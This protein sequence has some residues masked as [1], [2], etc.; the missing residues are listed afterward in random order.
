M[1]L[2]YCFRIPWIVGLCYKRESLLSVEAQ[3]R[4]KVHPSILPCSQL[5]N[6]YML[7]RLV[8]ERVNKLF[9]EKSARCKEVS[10]ASNQKAGSTTN[11]E[12]GFK[13]LLPSSQEWSQNCKQTFKVVLTVSSAPV[14]DVPQEDNRLGQGRNCHSPL[15]PK[16]YFC[17]YSMSLMRRA[18]RVGVG[19]RAWH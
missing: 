7:G 11:S 10:E 2:C 12:V 18:E 6:Q 8:L 1:W 14:E 9:R 17:S 13:S 15:F 4:D 16:L 5:F 3:T 19:C